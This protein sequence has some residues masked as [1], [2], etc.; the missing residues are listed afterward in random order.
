MFVV[1]L[2]CFL[3]RTV[4][5]FE[6]L[7]QKCFIADFYLDWYALPCHYSF[8]T[9]TQQ[10]ECVFLYKDCHVSS[11]LLLDVTRQRN[12]LSPKKGALQAFL[13][14]PSVHSGW[15]LFFFFWMISLDQAILCWGSRALSFLLV[16]TKDNRNKEFI[17]CSQD[18][19]QRRMLMVLVGRKLEA[20]FVLPLINITFSDRTP[21]VDFLTCHFVN[22]CQI[23]LS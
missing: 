19:G 11:L 4:L 21:Q 2:L 10:Q 14:F 23:N 20:N 5:K 9:R 12:C 3:T 7:H 6:K 17:A 8:H 22:I 1:L 18:S 16:C 15:F 13:W